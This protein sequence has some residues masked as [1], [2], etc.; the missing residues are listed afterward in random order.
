MRNNAKNIL[1]MSSHSNAQDNFLDKEQFANQT[2]NVTSSVDASASIACDVT[3]LGTTDVNYKLASGTLPEGLSLS[4]DGRITGKTTQVGTTKVKVT[5][6]AD[7]YIDMTREITI[8]VKPAVRYNG[9]LNEFQIG[10]EVATGRKI[11]ND[12]YKVGDKIMTGSGSSQS[13]NE[14]KRVEYSAKGLPAG[15]TLAK[16]G[17][18]T[19]TPTVST[20]SNVE[21]TVYG[22]Y[23]GWR[24]EEKVSLPETVKFVV[25]DA[26]GNEP[27]ETVPTLTDKELAEKAQKEAEAAKA[28]ATK[29]K[30]DAATAQEAAD[31]AKKAAE[32]AQARAEKAEVEAGNNSEA[33]KAARAEAKAAQEAAEAAQKAADDAKADADTKIADAEAKAKAAQEAANA[34][35]KALDDYIAANKDTKVEEKGSDPVALTGIVLG[36]VGL[37]AGLGAL[38]MN[39]LKKKTH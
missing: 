31:A 6:Y 1:W 2:V 33:A 19:G 37:L 22:I 32:A 14:I 27:V 15:L 24:G 39:L 13:Q 38:I 25:K 17:T 34:A 20:I 3:K 29:A 18:L 8:V 7:G 4:A 11:E 9:E 12:A 23:Q 30:A 21:I 26:S 16:D 36:T 10:H 35:K 5:L 28:E